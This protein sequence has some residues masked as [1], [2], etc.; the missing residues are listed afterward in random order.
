M[1]GGSGVVLAGWLLLV[2]LPWGQPIR[3][4][5]GNVTYCGINADGGA[6]AA[7]GSNYYVQGTNWACQDQQSDLDPTTIAPNCWDQETCEALQTG[8]YDNSFDVYHDM[9]YAY[10]SDVGWVVDEAVKAGQAPTPEGFVQQAGALLPNQLGPSGKCPAGHP[11]CGLQ[12]YLREGVDEDCVSCYRRYRYSADLGAIYWKIFQIHKKCLKASDPPCQ[13]QTCYC[14]TDAPYYYPQDNPNT[15][16][17]YCSSWAKAACRR[18]VYK[19]LHKH[20]DYVVTSYQDYDIM[21]CSLGTDQ[22]ECDGCVACTDR[23]C[24]S[25][26]IHVSQLLRTDVPL[27]TVLAS[28]ASYNCSRS[29]CGEGPRTCWNKTCVEGDSCWPDCD[30]ETYVGFET[31]ASMG[32]YCSNV[33]PDSNTY[34]QPIE[35]VV[36]CDHGNFCNYPNA[37]ARVAG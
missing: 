3:C 8:P 32:F 30:P 9:P 27:A 36:C 31:G 17:E 16:E 33:D 25:P 18:K 19:C 21:F 1:K 4:F 28:N 23:A 12:T 5:E 34:R 22:P 10:V 26:V 35:Q 14:T 13:N 29:T 20:S 15:G 2:S 7:G 11:A 37:G 6:L 24:Q